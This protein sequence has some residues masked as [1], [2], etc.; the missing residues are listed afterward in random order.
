MDEPG[1]AGGAGDVR[2]RHVGEL[3]GTGPLGEGGEHPQHAEEDVAD[4]QMHQPA[5]AVPGGLLLANASH[6]L[7]EE[8]VG[9]E[10][11]LGVSYHC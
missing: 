4:Q 10:R 6:F 9:A 8:G 11:V 7:R 1:G 5:E 3:A 2:R